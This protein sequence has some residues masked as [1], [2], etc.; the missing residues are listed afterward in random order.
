[1]RTATRGLIVNVKLINSHGFS[2]LIRILQDLLHH[3]A[4]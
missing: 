3:V 2:F 1:M 4:V